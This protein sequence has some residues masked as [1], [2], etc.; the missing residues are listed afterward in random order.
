[1]N[2][3]LKRGV[4]FEFTAHQYIRMNLRLARVTILIKSVVLQATRKLSESTEA[5]NISEG[6]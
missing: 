4:I 1:M 3:M 2:H 5:S 6:I